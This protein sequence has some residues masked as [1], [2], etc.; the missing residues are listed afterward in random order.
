M[1]FQGGIQRVGK[2]GFIASSEVEKGKFTFHASVAVE[3]T[4]QTVAV[5]GKFYIAESATNGL[6]P[7]GSYEFGA[8]GKMLQGL[9]KGDDGKVRYYE[10]GTPAYAGLIQDTN[11]DYYYISGSS[12]AAVTNGAYTVSKT[13]GLLPVGT[14][15]FGADGKMLQGIVEK[16]G[17]L[18]YYSKTEPTTTGNYWRYVDGVPVAW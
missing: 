13:N 7:A 8:D 4:I 12:M 9:I 14:Y 17:T 5:K 15:E 18:Y 11:G 3:E 2:F 10:N 16:D 6:L 1:S